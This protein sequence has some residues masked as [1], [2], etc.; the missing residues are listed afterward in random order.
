MSEQQLIQLTESIKNT[1]EVK[2]ESKVNGSIRRLDEK[3]D[4]YITVD[5]EWK[6]EKVEPLI[7]AHKTIQNLAI[8]IKWAASIAIAVTV[9]L[10]LNMAEE[11]ISK[12]K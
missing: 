2:I 4:N 7:D 5:I 10:K 11:F 1:I 8:F 9:L 12:I 3:L 6:K